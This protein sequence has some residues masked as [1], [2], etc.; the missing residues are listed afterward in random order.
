MNSIHTADTGILCDH[1][2]ATTIQQ[3]AL[4]PGAVKALPLCVAQHSA[5][6]SV[7]RILGA[8]SIAG[9]DRVQLYWY[10]SIQPYPC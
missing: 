3:P 5:L 1:H 9:G 4:L 2:I 8:A 6:H 10:T 7:I